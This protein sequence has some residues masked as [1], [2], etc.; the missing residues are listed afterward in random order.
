MQQEP[1]CKH[2]RKK[3][4]AIN[5]GRC[6]SPLDWCLHNCDVDVN[7]CAVLIAEDK[8]I[9]EFLNKDSEK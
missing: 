4:R 2:E 5:A 8:A 1:I 7:T 3:T 9:D 6:F